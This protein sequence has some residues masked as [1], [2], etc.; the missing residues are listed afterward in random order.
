VDL[1]DVVKT[2]E[3]RHKAKGSI[4]TRAHPAYSWMA[5]A[6]GVRGTARALGTTEV[7][8]SL[9]SVGIVNENLGRCFKGRSNFHG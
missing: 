4:N 2:K 1:K 8:G 9:K 3:S 6:V 5:F 7:H